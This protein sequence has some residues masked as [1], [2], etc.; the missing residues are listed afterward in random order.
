MFYNHVK[1]SSSKPCSP[2]SVCLCFFDVDVS[3][4]CG[5]IVEFL[6]LDPGGHPLFSISK[7][8]QFNPIFLYRQAGA[9]V[10]SI[11]NATFLA[12]SS[13]LFSFRTQFHN[14]LFTSFYRPSL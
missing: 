4:H 12:L 6:F 13:L 3:F 14:S 9:T 8:S 10:V 5:A 2:E 1:L 11:S 7:A